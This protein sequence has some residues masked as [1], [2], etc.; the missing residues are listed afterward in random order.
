M[1]NTKGY[2][3]YKKYWEDQAGFIGNSPWHNEKIL[4][5]AISNNFEE[6]LKQLNF[7]N[8]SISKDNGNLTLKLKVP[9]NY[10]IYL[11]LINNIL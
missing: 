7:S 6:N 11:N 3:T 2:V 8:H 4:K 9:Y 5:I 1:F 10:H